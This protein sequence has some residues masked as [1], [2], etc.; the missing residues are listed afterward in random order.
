MEN[1]MENQT[2][3]SVMREFRRA[4]ARS[5]FILLV[6]MAAVII[7]K[8]ILSFFL[9]EAL[10]ESAAPLISFAVVFMGVY[11]KDFIRTFDGRLGEERGRRSKVLAGT[12][13]Y[14]AV[15]VIAFF[16]CALAAAVFEDF[17]INVL[18]DIKT[19]P[20]LEGISGIIYVLYI[21]FAEPAMYAFIFFGFVQ[22]RM[23]KYD[24][25]AA[26]FIAAVLYAFAHGMYIFVPVAFLQG[27]ILANSAAKNKSML[28][29]VKIN[30]LSAILINMGL[31]ITDRYAGVPFTVY[32]IILGVFTIC[33]V[34]ALCISFCNRLHGRKKELWEPKYVRMYL[35]KGVVILFILAAM[36]EDILFMLT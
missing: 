9:P 14:V 15:T 26:G 36:A 28:T 19:I 1:V 34:V 6:Y 29:T 4:A 10:T 11:K 13:L 25:K 33:G 30:I 3:R 22:G 32:T 24:E 31:Y 20:R 21:C 18:I 35:L 16:V 8:L 23:S 17:G 27:L 12:S 7:L 2:A 5:G